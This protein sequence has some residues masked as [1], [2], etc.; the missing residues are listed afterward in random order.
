MTEVAY[1]SSLRPLDCVLRF[2]GFGIVKGLV[3][4]RTRNFDLP[5]EVLLLRLGSRDLLFGLFDLDLLSARSLLF[6]APAIVLNRLAAPT[7][8]DKELKYF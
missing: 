7:F 1:F 3:L 8:F 2:I 5:L 4:L 6:P